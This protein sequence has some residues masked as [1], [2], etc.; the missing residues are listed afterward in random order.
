M[1]FSGFAYIIAFLLGAGIVFYE[2]VYNNGSFIS[3]YLVIPIGVAIAGYMLAPQLDW[4]WYKRFPMQLDSKVRS[5]FESNSEFYRNLSADKKKI[6]DERI[7]LYVEAKDWK[8]IGMEESMPYDIRC[9]IAFEPVRLTLNQKNFLMEPFDTVVV[10]QNPFL[11][12]Q[13]PDRYHASELFKDDGVVLFSLKHVLPAFREPEKYFNIVLYEY[14]RIMQITHKEIIFPEL[15]EEFWY[16]L[17]NVA[18]YGHREIMGVIGLTEADAVAVAI[19]HY[20]TYGAYFGNIYPDLYAS[21]QSIF[22]TYH[23]SFMTITSGED[24]SSSPLTPL[25][26][27]QHD[28]GKSDHE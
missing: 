7:S 4:W 12:P 15:T 2:Y 28:D 18:S 3:P 11:S 17:Y 10:Y 24:D 20:F 23:L 6:F 9:I 26:I 8:Y 21:L 16:N 1:K 25:E 5:I 19:H 13:F 22:N 27:D 14:A